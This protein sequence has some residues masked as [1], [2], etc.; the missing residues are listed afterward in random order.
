MN[1]G[2]N[3]GRLASPARRALL[4]HS[5]LVAGLWTLGL[6]PSE[7]QTTAPAAAAAAAAA[8]VPGFGI[9]LRFDAQG[10]LTVL[11]Y[12]VELGQGTHSAVRLM[13]AEEL[14]LPLDR[15]RVEQAPVEA[16]YFS[17]R[18]KDYASFGSFGTSLSWR[19]IGQLCATARAMLIQAAAARWG[20]PAADCLS[21]A[22]EGG[23]VLHPDGRQ[24]LPYAALLAE[25]AALPAPKDAPRKPAAERRFVGKEGS[26]RIDLPAKVNGSARFGIDARRPGMLYAALIHAPR[27]GA[28]LLG[29]DERPAKPFPGVRGIVRLPGTLAA[30]AAL[31][32]V[33]DSYW[34]ARQALQALQPRWSAGPHAATDSEALRAELLAATAR[35]AGKPFDQRDDPR[36]DDAAV[37]QALS[38]A[39]SHG[40]GVL[41]ISYDV[42][43]LAHATMEPMNALA[44]VGPKGAALWL[45]TQSAG[46]TQRGVARALGLKPEQVQINAMLIGGGFG[47]RLEHGFA[48]QAALIAKQMKRPV[49]L[50]WSRETDMRAGGYRPAA[51]ARVRLALDSEGWPQALRVDAANPSLL[52][53]SSLSNGEPSP[54]FDWSVG[55]GWTRHDYGVGPMQLGW[56]RVDAGVPCGYWRSVGAS[57]NTF[58]YECSID[59]AAALAGIDPLAYRLRML[60]KKP[61][62][63]ALL[64]ALAERAGWGQVLPPGHFQGLA[65]SSGNAARSAH[66]VQISVPAP[67]RFRIERITAAVDVGLVVNPDAVRAQLMGGTIFGLSAALAGEITLKDGQVQQANFDSYPLL[68]LAQTPPIDLVVLGSGEQPRGVGEEGPASIGPALANALFAASGRDPAKA[69]TRLPLTRAGWVLEG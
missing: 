62:T 24:R 9:W 65:L 33:A 38:Q 53:Y 32:V 12:V 39:I 2:Q 22:G 17:P 57:Q 41:D 49:Q 28:E 67:G 64:R 45:S 63:L 19:E 7:A 30:L 10:G 50:I 25:A 54:D 58:F 34:T 48:V 23:Q 46:D 27:F 5:S 43:F 31:A 14:D 18:I 44:E 47:R 59:R 52:E 37:A 3:P 55:M 66:I 35:G 1:A 61:N 4:L 16:R 6:A 36:I 40:K 56:S 20:V 51:A 11:S 69:I 29:V 42:P 15:V 8:G 26:Q 13:A 21:N 68:T 60:E